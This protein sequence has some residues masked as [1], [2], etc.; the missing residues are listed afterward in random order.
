[1]RF[2]VVTLFPEMFQAI[3]AYGVTGRAFTQGAASV[4]FH[5]PRD[6]SESAYGSVDDRPYGGGP[7]MVMQVRPLRKA[8]ASAQ[9]G[10]PKAPVLYLS[11]QGARLTQAK[12]EALLNCPR[13][14][15]LAGRYEGIDNRVLEHDVDEEISLGDFVLSGGEC[16][17]MCLMDGI[18]RLLP[19]VLGCGDSAV[20]ESFSKGLLD[21]P[22][23]TRPETIDDQTVPPVLLAGDHAHV[24]RWRLQ[25]RLWATYHKRPDLFAQYAMNKEERALLNDFLKQRGEDAAL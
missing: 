17:A 25:Q 7:G 4:H 19:G 2:D 23:Y 9:D 10:F 12:I 1:M 13:L 8:I 11:P 24:A 5:N 16:A 6:Y 21:H 20:E 14:V 15:L 3:T 22:H 18:I